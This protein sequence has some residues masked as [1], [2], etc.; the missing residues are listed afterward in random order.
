LGPLMAPLRESRW[1]RLV[2]PR[3]ATSGTEPGSWLGLAIGA[4]DGTG[5]GGLLGSAQ[6]IPTLGPW[7]APLRESCW[8]RWAVPQLVTAG[9]GPGSWLGLATGALGGTGLGEIM[10]SAPR[11]PTLGPRMAPLRESCWGA[12]G[13]PATGDR[14]DRAR[15]V[16]GTCHR[17][18]EWHRTRRASGGHDRGT[19]GFL[20]RGHLQPLDWNLGILGLRGLDC[21]LVDGLEMQRLDW[22]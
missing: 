20:G 15:R 16:A 4:S 21:L 10:G 1:G 17:G 13:G 7:M 9:T 12:T 11:K 8:G 5:F 6:R 3:L 18:L 19:Q 14:W 2:A 22:H